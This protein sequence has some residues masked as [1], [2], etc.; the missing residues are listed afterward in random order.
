MAEQNAQRPKRMLRS[1]SSWLEQQQLEQKH[2]PAQNTSLRIYN[3]ASKMAI[4][5]R[6]EYF[7]PKGV[8]TEFCIAMCW[9]R[10]ELPTQLGEGV[11]GE[12]AGGRE[13]GEEERG[14]EQGVG[15]GG[16]GGRNY[17]TCI[18]S[19]GCIIKFRTNKECINKVEYKV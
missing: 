17:E 6:W 15:E 9:G 14:G 13:W 3:A 5:S 1:N 16:G 2:L 8:A 12:C 7:S 4:T 18:A 19:C 10:R 11:G